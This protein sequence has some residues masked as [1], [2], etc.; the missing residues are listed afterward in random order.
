MFWIAMVMVNAVLAAM[1]CMFVGLV[2]LQEGI[3]VVAGICPIGAGLQDPP[4]TCRPLVRVCPVVAQKLI[5]LF[6]DVKDA[7]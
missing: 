7:T 1:S 4:L 3:A 5:K 6:D 2:N